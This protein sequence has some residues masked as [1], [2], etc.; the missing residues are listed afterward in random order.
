MAANTKKQFVIDA[1]Y[2]LAFLLPDE[3]NP[4]VD[5][6][7]NQYRA[8][9]I[10][11][12]SSPLFLFEVINGLKTALQRKRI[13]L[14]YCKNRIEEF[15]DYGI[16]IYPIDYMKTFLLADKHSLTFYDASY[17]FLAKQK[18]TQ[19]LSLDKKLQPKFF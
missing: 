18:K 6:I 5:A 1:S 17:V 13:N 12:I 4:Q 11:L 9:L 2:A 7:F 8:D 14:A 15:L 3:Y 19:I 10:Q 16:A